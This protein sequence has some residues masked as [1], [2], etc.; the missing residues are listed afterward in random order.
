MAGRE[1]GF[2]AQSFA[3]GLRAVRRLWV[4][5]AGGYARWFDQTTNEGSEPV[6]V[7][8]VYAGQYPSWGLLLP[9]APTDTGGRYAVQAPSDPG[10]LYSPGVAGSVFAGVGALTPTETSVLPDNAY[11][12][13]SWTITLPPGA[14]RAF[15]HYAVS[16]AANEVAA[17]QTQAEALSQGTE[18][19]MFDGLSSEE[20]AAVINFVVPQ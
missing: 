16:R 19:G 10:G 18:P 14:T 13:W 15:L 11:Y 2:S 7:N 6:E 12:Q 3:D 20:R 9:V 4:P 8:L 5:A 1:F 17:V